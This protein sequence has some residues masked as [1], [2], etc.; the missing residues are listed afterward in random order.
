[1]S[2]VQSERGLLDAALESARI[3]NAVAA[4]C[5]ASSGLLSAMQEL[6]SHRELMDRF[7]VE[8]TKAGAFSALLDV[9]VETGVAER[10]T[11]DGRAAYRH[12]AGVVAA[13]RG[14]DGSLARYRPKLAL[15]EPWFGDAHAELIH[16]SNRRLLGDDLSFFRSASA[17]IRFDAGFLDAWRTNLSNPL[18][19]F[20]RVVAVREMVSRGRR[21]LDLAG[22]LG[23]GA[24]R[25]AE[26]SPDGCEIVLVDKSEDFLREARLL[27]FPR[28]R[29]R[30]VA[31][32]LNTGLPPLG[33]ASFDGVLFNGA[34]HF[35]RD[36]VR[37]LREIHRV[38]RPGGLLVIGHCFCR[39]DFGDEAMHDLYFSMMADHA[40]PI[41]F[42]TLRSLLADHGF[43]EFRQY[44]RGSH[45]YLLAER[46]PGDLPP[47]DR[48]ADRVQGQ[49][50]AGD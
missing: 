48:T 18:Y 14:D 23:Y 26:L 2:G 31:R 49:G 44:H 39:S 17:R 24:Q 50:W 35:I 13:R 37:R 4:D 46:L 11:V 12:R 10:V 21:F 28:A 47:T 22:G 29:V 40:W 16:A 9:L 1:V 27:V 36:K 32:D 45:S 33:P 30:F 38:L 43:Q 15:L 7:R 6:S 5:A 19:E 3:F 34:F 41:R 8:P 42:D 20:G 25:L